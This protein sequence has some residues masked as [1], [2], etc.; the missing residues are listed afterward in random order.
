MGSPIGLSLDDRKIRYT[1]YNTGS[2]KGR[3]GGQKMKSLFSRSVFSPF[4][5]TIDEKTGNVLKINGIRTVHSDDVYD[6]SITSLI[7]YT[8]K[9][10]NRAMTLREVDFA[11]LKNVGVYP[12]N[13]LIIARRFPGPVSSD[14]TKVNSTPMATMISW[15]DEGDTDF[16]T[17]KYNEEWVESDADFTNVLNEAGEEQKISKDEG[18]PLGGAL[19]GGLNILPFAGFSEPLQRLVFA[20]LGL[21][22][23]P[24]NLPLGNPN[25]I[26]EAKRRKTVGKGQ[27]ESGLACDIDIKMEVE[28]E[29]KFINGID[30][31]LVYLD[32][33]QNALTFGTSDAS[34]QFGSGFGNLA[35]DTLNKLVTGNFAAIFEGM[36]KVVTA[37]Y[38]KVKEF[39]GGV[40]D[41]LINP[42][43]LDF[44][45]IGATVKNVATKFFT[46]TEK[47]IGSIVGKYKVRLMGI[48]NA[49]TGS[50]SCPWHI[51]IGNPK[52]PIFSSGDM[53]L[54]SVDVSIG[55]ILSFNDLPSTIKFILT[56]SN[57]RPLGASEIFHRF[58]C[59]KGRSYIRVKIEQENIDTQVSDI[60]DENIYNTSFEDLPIQSE[61]KIGR[62]ATHSDSVYSQLNGEGAQFYDDWYKFNPNVAGSQSTPNQSGAGAA[63]NS[64]NNTPNPQPTGNAA[65]QQRADAAAGRGGNNAST[66]GRSST[67]S[68]TG[69]T[70]RT[71]KKNR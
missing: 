28:Y 35:S 51:T 34:F 65:A 71:R 46:V 64:L 31:T 52:R 39:V 38:N 33:I 2:V 13:R 24:Y 66:P 11:F 70:P 44:K 48:I 22:E 16:F 30:P 21:V 12:N 63:N 36:K 61:G 1:V 53:H 55:S 47:T 20:E 40:V 6:T 45:K 57:A 49:L 41:F 60:S 42:Q 15:F 54:K 37:L 69:G 25:L 9:K 23:D 8:K 50:P 26:R 29:Q 58:N 18:N 67:T 10:G 17:V 19:G 59:S 62:G 7:N 43:N 32:I 14:L 4:P 56:F 68:N 27:A 3:P 5:E